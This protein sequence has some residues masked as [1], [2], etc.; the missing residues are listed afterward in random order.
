MMDDRTVLKP[1]N[2]ELEKGSYRPPFRPDHID[3]ILDGNEG[4][5]PKLDLENILGVAGPEL[6]RRYPDKYPLEVRLASMHGVDPSQV[7]V[8]AGADDAIDRCMRA[9]AGP[10]RPVVLTRPTFEMIARYASVARAPVVHVPWPGGAFPL[11]AF[12]A[13]AGDTAGVLAVVSPNNP[14]GA[15]VTRDDLRALSHRFPGAL[16][17]LDLAYGEFAD[18]DLSAF[19]LTLPNAVVL[20]SFSKALGMAGLR[21][22][23]AVGPAEI[24]AVLRAAG[25]PYS[26]SGPSVQLVLAALSERADEIQEYVRRVKGEREQLEGLLSRLQLH[27]SP[28]QGN[29]VFCRTPRAPRL[30]SFL[31]ALGIS[32]RDFPGRSGLEEDIRITCPGET[33]EFGRLCHAIETAC[34]PEALL[35][36]MDGVLVDVSASYHQA[37]KGAAKAFGVTLTDEDI[38]RA[39]NQPG[40]NND[41]EVT[42]RLLAERG[43]AE[44]LERVKGT[45][46][47]LYQG[48]AQH[49]GLW[50]TETLIPERRTLD[51][52]AA[53]FPLGIVTGRPRGDA[54]R[55]L[56]A[57]DLTSMFRVVVCMED[58]P[59]K[60]DPAPV[61]LALKALG[62]SRAWMLGDTPDD[63]RAA[64]GA[65]VVPLGILPPGG[66]DL[67][68]QALESA[69][70]GAILNGIEELEEMIP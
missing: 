9:Y 27:P 23:Y 58:A 63:I 17:M 65:G 3:L 37:V 2:P 43:L 15:V 48:T 53:R 6:M 34:A 31:A 16:L 47:E 12:A 57:H 70:A 26:V 36:D 7:L 33:G 35:F 39:K 59:L 4:W 60:P 69:G 45:F 55:F 52:L 56:E 28:S 62:V 14:T 66:G 41:W 25:H 50:T 54:M 5:P 32:V 1:V 8:T 21:V 10:E 42:R 18:E 64:R 49:P 44:S 51:A 46:E 22:G 19:A 67:R 24:L 30:H 13:G 68:R 38:R 29:F 40:A 61:R 11:E 20:R